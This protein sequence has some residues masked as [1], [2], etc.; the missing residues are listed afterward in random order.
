MADPN[1]QNALSNLK[2]WCSWLVVQS[3]DEG[4]VAQFVSAFGFCSRSLP[5][6]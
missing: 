1:A 5:P 4:A 3:G 2:V 6:F